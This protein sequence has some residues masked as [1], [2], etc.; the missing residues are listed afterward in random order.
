MILGLANGPNDTNGT[1][2]DGRMPYPTDLS[3][4]ES[5]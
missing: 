2:I 4:P 1:V 5:V 3:E